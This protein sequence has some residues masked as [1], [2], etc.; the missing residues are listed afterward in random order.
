MMLVFQNATFET[1]TRFCSK[2]FDVQAIHYSVSRQQYFALFGVAV[3]SLAAKDQPHTGESQLFRKV[4]RVGK[5][6]A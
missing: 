3:D 5:F 6:S 4:Q 1:A 2:F